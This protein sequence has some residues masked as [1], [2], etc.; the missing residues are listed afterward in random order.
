MLLIFS[1]PVSA[2]IQKSNHSENNNTAQNLY[3]SLKKN[4]LKAIYHYLSVY[5]QEHQA[6]PLLII[7]SQAKLAYL[8][9]RPG[10]A[11]RLY[12]TILQQKPHF[13][14]AQLE[15]ARSYRADRQ[16]GNALLLFRELS[17]R[18]PVTSPHYPEITR[19]ITELTRALS[20]SLLLSAGSH[21]T[22]NYYQT[23]LPKTHCLH[24]SP[25]GSCYASLIPQ[26][27]QAVLQ[28]RSDWD[29]RR[30]TPL[31][32]SH[33]LTQHYR[34]STRYDAANQAANTVT[35]TAKTGYHYQDRHTLWQLTP[36]LEQHF[37]A[38]RRFSSA[39]GLQ[40]YLNQQLS[41]EWSLGGLAVLRQHRYQPYLHSHN[42]TEYQLIPQI[43]WR[44]HPAATLYLQAETTVHKK[45][46]PINITGQL[47]CIPA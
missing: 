42:G 31:S 43:T 30:L 24:Y 3:L 9:Q 16:L 10:V 37:S 27:S 11:I 45:M 5:Q 2:T 38:G 12:N 15:L 25:D 8:N 33:F 18:L 21:Y 7:F 29:L 46:I 1:L 40:T 44:P 17:Q 35:L 14:T 6:D 19:A 20:W 39:Y 13:F 32:G 26:R 36:L 34:V 22:D 4:N 41:P 28:W 47:P 23:P